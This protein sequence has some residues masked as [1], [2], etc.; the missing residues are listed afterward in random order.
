MKLAKKEK[1]VERK[2]GK[3]SKSAVYLHNY[4]MKSGIFVAQDAVCAGNKESQ[5]L[6]DQKAEAAVA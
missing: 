1:A 4:R 3:V 2:L 5:R 6:R